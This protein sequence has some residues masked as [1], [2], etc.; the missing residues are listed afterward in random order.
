MHIYERAEKFIHQTDNLIIMVSSG[1][2]GR[3]LGSGTPKRLTLKS[4]RTL[5][6]ST[7]FNFFTRRKYSD[8][9]CII[10]NY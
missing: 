9:I 8:V 3:V 7:M 6:L 4:K 10:K 1:E 5:A 2:T